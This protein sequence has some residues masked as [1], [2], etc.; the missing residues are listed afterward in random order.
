MKI[1]IV[2]NLY[3][4]YY[5]GGYEIRC[6]L[7]AEGLHQA[8]HDVRV[9]TSTY[10]LK[11]GESRRHPHEEHNG[12]P[13]QRILGQYHYTPT[14]PSKWPYFIFGA[15]LQLR[16]ACYFIRILDE[17]KPDVVNWWSTS[18]LTKAILPIPHLR[19]IPDLVW[20]EDD[21]IVVER[22]R[23]RE[24]DRGGRRGRASGAQKR[25]HGAG[26]RG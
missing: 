24:E 4:P 12:V 7:V 2:S 25:S 8:G 23:E 22:E 17:F 14:T 11:P 10:G 26:I 1:L 9:L 18:G 21:W 6:A 20:I 19:G 16:D 3:P 5:I 13:V 15:R